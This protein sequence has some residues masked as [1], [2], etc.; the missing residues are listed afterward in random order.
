MTDDGR[1][2]TDDKRLTKAAPQRGG[3]CGTLTVMP[4][5][6]APARRNDP[7]RPSGRAQDSFRHML[8]R[9]SAFFPALALALA[10]VS[11]HRPLF[12]AE[13]SERLHYQFLMP[14]LRG[15]L[16]VNSMPGRN[17]LAGELSAGL[18]LVFEGPARRAS[19]FLQ[20]SAGYFGA[21]PAQSRLHTF[22]LEM[23]IGVGDRR[24]RGM[25]RPRLLVGQRAGAPIVG[26]RTGLALEVLMGGLGLQVDYILIGGGG[27]QVQGIDLM[28]T[29]DLV[30]LA[31]LA[32]RAWWQ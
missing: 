19:L 20:P 32:V 23:G 11:M 12:A 4:R 16:G 13:P 21:G 15:G 14:S 26:L 5:M 25:L 29:T 2:T 7:R 28:L 30:P 1:Q 10:L 6:H 24:I 31:L 22:Q 8:P 9:A 27:S 17:A 3:E 18:Q